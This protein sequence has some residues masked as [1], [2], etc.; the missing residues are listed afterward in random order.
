MSSG[1]IIISSMMYHKFSI[2]RL[3][4]CIFVYFIVFVFF[5]QGSFSQGDVPLKC[6]GTPNEG[7]PKAFEAP[8][9]SQPTS[10]EPKIPNAAG[11]FPPLVHDSK[12]SATEPPQFSR[13]NRRINGGK[14]LCSE[15]KIHALSSGKDIWCM[16]VWGFDAFY[17]KIF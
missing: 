11:V 5:F 13:A 9:F 3:H 14:Q 2:N 4:R 15:T 16:N 12:L 8:L 17:S 1:C 7:S 6:T 10:L